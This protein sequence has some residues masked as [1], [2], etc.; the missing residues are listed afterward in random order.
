MIPFYSSPEK[1]IAFQTEANRWLGTPFR[2]NSAV[3]GPDGGVDCV[4]L[5][6]AIHHNCGA[7]NLRSIERLPLDWHL[8]H[9]ASA[10]IDFFH[11][12]GVRERLTRVE[13]EEEPLLVGDLVAIKTARCVHHLG[14]YLQDSIGKHLLHVP[15]DGTVQRWSI[16]YA[17]LSGK[18]ASVWRIMEAKA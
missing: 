12:P 4:G 16:G 9:S 11:T 13:F 5:C 17:P 6:A 1:Q 10:I 3:C 2:F 14:L 18:I 7:C 15:V 8:H